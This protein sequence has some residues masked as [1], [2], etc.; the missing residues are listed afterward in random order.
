MRTLSDGLNEKGG[1]GVLLWFEKLLLSLFL[2]LRFGSC[3]LFFPS[4]LF[5]FLSPKISFYFLVR[6]FVL[7][8]GRSPTAIFLIF[9]RNKVVCRNGFLCGRDNFFLLK[10]L[11]QDV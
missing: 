4:I 7:V 8:C 1:Q 10:R 5:S 9:L 2:V 6:R 11:L 3:S